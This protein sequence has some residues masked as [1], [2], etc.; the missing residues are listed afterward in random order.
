MKRKLIGILMAA[1]MIVSTMPFI[2]AAP[3]FADEG[4][5]LATREYVV[6]Q[7]VQSVGRSNFSGNAYMLSTF[8]DKDDID[9]DYVGDFEK[10]VSNGLVRGYEDKTLRPKEN[11][12]RIEALA[13]LARCIPE[14]PDDVGEP[15]EFTD[16]PDWAEENIDDLTRAGIVKGYGNGLLGAD[17]NI[18][19]E[20]V[21]LLTDRSDELLN[22]VPV[23]ESF[24]GHINNK[25]FRNVQLPS[26][27]VID[28]VHGA[29]IVPPN[30]W[31]YMSDIQTQIFD[32]ENELM[33]KLMDGELEYQPGSAE[34]RVHDMLLC[35]QDSK[36]ITE[37]DKALVQGWRQQIL[38]AKSV[39]ELVNTTTEIAKETGINVL[40]TVDVAQNPE[41]GV[42]LPMITLKSYSPIGMINYRSATK[43]LFGD[44]YLNTVKDVVKSMGGEFSDDD[45]KRAVELQSLA[46]RDTNYAPSISQGIDIRKYSDQSITQDIIDKDIEAMLSEH[47]D[48]DPETMESDKEESQLFTAAEAE[49]ATKNIDFCDILNKMGFKNYDSVEL[50]NKDTLSE[51]D[52][53]FTADNLNALKANALFGLIDFN[54]PLNDDEAAAA[55]QI[56]INAGMALLYLSIDTDINLLEEMAKALI[57]TMSIY[58]EE[59]GGA[60]QDDESVF[61]TENMA[62]I[63]RY[64]PN[65][66]GLIYCDYYYDD[67]TSLDVADMLD[68]IWNEYIE[69]FEKNTWMSD[70]TKQNAIKKITNMIAVIG[71]PDNYEFPTITSPEQGG[72]VF[73]N[74]VSVYKDVLNTKVRQCSE[75]EFLREGM[76]ASP[77]TVNAFYAPQLNIICIMSAILNSPIYDPEADRAENLGAIGAIVGHEV[78]HAFDITGS[79]F[80]ENGCLKNW[81]T[82]KDQEEYQKRIQNFVEYYK[83]FEVLQGVPQDSE[84]TIG[85][86]MADFAGLRCV[87]NILEGDPEAQKKALES[88]ATFWADLGNET[89]KMNILAMDEHSSNN[90][91]VDAVVASMDEFYELY[92]VKEGDRM[93]VAPENRLK[94]W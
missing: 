76:L 45:I 46:T 51:I 80:D 39:E 23:S 75:K 60:D 22:T 81:W 68:D 37:S 59:S 28:A 30:S 34:Q 79:Q 35:I 4:A 48:V 10:A 27:P 40:F 47:P 67:Q 26:E 92:D 88:Y 11:V 49:K 74:T 82:E 73:S 20:Q 2:S 21:G 24:Y 33:K 65:D 41:T 56:S 13:M 84:K 32:R 94:L 71:Y 63:R 52:K 53:A 83:N 58:T 3:V 19:V 16:V 64:L 90:V 86:N 6:S 91:R 7:F 72:T 29:V 44:R 36:T 1:A 14:V 18:T 9:E 38:N 5:E 12:T 31:S 54:A 70:E 42:A 8:A 93:Y 78:G 55:E 61:N 57:N 25:T 87:L 15:I 69:T 17:D 43:E 50:N 62:L 89:S 85:E 77:D 66:I